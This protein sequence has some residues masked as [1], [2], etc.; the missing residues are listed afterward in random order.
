[1]SRSAKRIEVRV[2]EGIS[3]DG[4]R[5]VVVLEEKSGQR[6]RLCFEAPKD[7]AIER[8]RPAANIRALGLGKQ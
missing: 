5:I 2:G 4:G 3:I 1:M 6:A 7:V 8:V